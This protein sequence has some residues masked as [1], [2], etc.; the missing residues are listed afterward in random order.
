MTAN[1]YRTIICNELRAAHIGKPLPW[2]DGQFAVRDQ[3]WRYFV[4]LRDRE[5]MTSGGFSARRRARTRPPKAII[6]NEDVS[7]LTAR[8]SAVS[9]APTTP[10]WRRDKWEIVVS[11]FTTL[12]K[13][14]C[15]PS[16]STPNCSN[17][18]LRLKY[19]ISTCGVPRMTRNR[20][21]PASHRESHPPT[22]WTTPVRGGFHDAM[23]G[24]EVP[25][26]A[27][28]P[29][30]EIAVFEPQILVAEFG[31]DLEG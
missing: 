12:N 17:E 13:A 5:G 19:A 26:H 1:I 22:F 9:K 20:P 8:W 7:S 6:A 24:A 11:D 31:V 21:H 10:T 14:P 28:T 18:D 30:V 27:G 29:Q 15:Y 4:D 23:P 2:R 25:G 16:R 3:W